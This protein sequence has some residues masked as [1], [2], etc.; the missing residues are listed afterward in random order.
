[1]DKK[2]NNEN[3][4]NK[5]ID[6]YNINNKPQLDK[7]FTNTKISSFITTNDK[8]NRTDYLNKYLVM[9]DKKYIPRIIYNTGI[10]KCITCSMEMT[11]IL[12]EGIQVCEKCGIQGKILVESNKPSF[13]DPPPEV[14]YFAYKRINHFN[15]C[16]SQFQGK[17]STIVIQNVYDKLLMEIKK[18]RI[19]N[20]AI[21]TNKKIRDYLKKL[22]LHKFYEHIPKIL[23]RLTGIPPPTLTKYTE[24][25]LRGMFREIQIPFREV[26]PDDRTNFISYDYV[27][28]KLLQ[29]L[30]LDEYAKYFKYLKDKTK[31]Y[32]TDL[33]WKQICKKLRWEFIKSI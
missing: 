7:S 5:I 23:Y 10:N 12:S 20:L 14:S 25:K 24:N 2:I 4:F 31:L 8:F 32:K 21:L 13:K 29:L 9:I 28:H 17:E 18:E 1:M 6:F 22:K 3:S 15:E 33:I 16:L 11:V 27:L 30:D 26:C 19:H